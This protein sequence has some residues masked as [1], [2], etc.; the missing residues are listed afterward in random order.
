MIQILTLMPN[1][2]YFLNDIVIVVRLAVLLNVLQNHNRT[3]TNKNYI[4]MDILGHPA[5]FHNGRHENH[6]LVIK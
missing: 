6:V 5:W 1:I 2:V 4:Y 3:I